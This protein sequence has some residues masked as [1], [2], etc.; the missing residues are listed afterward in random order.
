MI[1]MT[2][3]YMA[4]ESSCRNFLKALVIFIASFV[5]IACGS[6][7]GQA[8]AQRQIDPAVVKLG[9]GFVSNTAKVNGTRLHYVRG[10]TGPAVIL[11]H[12]W[13]QDWYEFRKIM[14]R[15]AKKFTVIAVDLRG[16]GGS[17]P[18][19]GG[20]DAAN[21]AEDVYQL[22]QQL[23]LEPVYVAGHDVGGTVAYAF[24]RLHPTAARGAMILEAPLAGIEPWEE[25]KRDPL[26]WHAGFHQTPDLPEKLIAGRQS[27]YFRHFFTSYTFNKKAITETDVAHYANAYAT[28]AQLRAGLEFYRAF[29]A[30]EKFNAEQRNEINVPFVL[31]GGDKSFANLL[32]K[33][34]EDMRAHGCKNV[35]IETIKNSKHYVAEDQPERVAELI[36]RYASS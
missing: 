34:A 2:Q 26:L 36:E 17:S 35:F 28:P 21:M 23:K 27:V 10:G 16:V 31:A 12:G 6:A 29:P 24:V 4:S 20:Y 13:P 15:L 1:S 30:N 11:I 9:K 33:M 25:V 7:F 8:Q 5:A 22:S 14:P 19:P 18:T 3:D 32:P